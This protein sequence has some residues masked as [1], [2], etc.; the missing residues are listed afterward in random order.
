MPIGDGE[1]SSVV[2]VAVAVAGAWVNTT[3]PLVGATIAV[4]VGVAGEGRAV[5]VAVDGNCVAEAVGEGST[6]R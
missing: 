5:A 3:G 6:E 4:D 2:P 1:A